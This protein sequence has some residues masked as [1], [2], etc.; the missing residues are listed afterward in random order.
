MARAVSL[1]QA[2]AP[3]EA[4]AARIGTSGTCH[5]LLDDG[6]QIL[7]NHAAEANAPFGWK[8]A[9][10]ERLPK[11]AGATSV[12]VL[13]IFPLAAIACVLIGTTVSPGFAA[14]RCLSR[15]GHRVVLKGDHGLEPYRPNK[16]GKELPVPSIFDARGAIF[17]FKNNKNESVSSTSPCQ[18]GSDMVNPYPINIEHQP[19]GC[20]SGGVIQGDVEPSWVWDYAYCNGAGFRV[21][22]SNGFFVEDLQI[23]K[24]WDGMR[25]SPKDT[26][27]ERIWLS[28]IRDDC[29]EADTLHGFTLRDSLL[30]GCHS[31]IS[32]SKAC[33][34]P[35]CTNEY[36]TYLDNVLIRLEAR[37]RKSKQGEIVPI[38]NVFYKTSAKKGGAWPGLSV[39]N[40]IWATDYIDQPPRAWKRMWSAVDRG[41]T[42]SHNVLLYLKDDKTPHEVTKTIRPPACFEVETGEDARRHWREARDKWI[43]AREH[44]MR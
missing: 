35:P 37:P 4:S 40:N 43:D 27:L 23:D 25:V 20:F 33:K 29:I 2:I 24:A 26:V 16:S 41:G 11:I 13:D 38:A 39:N 15:D 8:S 3:A 9:D 22:Y 44:G 7:S 31:G 30:D 36:T 17:H 1:R 21:A 18:T 6:S 34:S 10:L 32:A 14:E 19:D 12:R 5:G 42:C 28:N